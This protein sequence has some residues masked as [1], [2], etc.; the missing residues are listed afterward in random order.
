VLGSSSV[1]RTAQA[2]RRKPA[3]KTVPFRGNVETRLRKLGDGVADATFLACAGLNRLGLAKHITMAMPVETML[4]AVAQGIVALEIASH[5]G[6]IR[7]MLQVINHKSSALAAACERAFLVSLDG[8]C[9]TPLAGHAVIT[10]SNIDFHAEA[11]TLDGMHVFT[12]VRAGSVADAVRM[13]R[14]AGEEIKLNG[15]A[16]LTLA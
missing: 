4:P 12:A 5:N 11:L 8:S 1:R 9:R 3:L 14:D 15:G 2:L 7:E 16:L 6:K 10:G 13:G